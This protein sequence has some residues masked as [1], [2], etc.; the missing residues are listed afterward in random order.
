MEKVLGLPLK[1]IPQWVISCGLILLLLIALIPVYRLTLYAFPY[2]DD[3]N[4]GIN[5]KYAFEHGAGFSKVIKTAYEDTVFTYNTWQ[6]TYSSVFLMVLMP[7]A[8]GYQYYFIGLCAIITMFV[9]GTCYLTYTVCSKVFKASK[10]SSFNLAS[11]VTLMNVELFYEAQQGFYWY[12]SSIHYTFMHSL[13]F[14]LLAEIIRIVYSDKKAGTAFRVAVSS[15]LAFIVAGANFVT[16]LQGFLMIL[17][18]FLAGV[19]VIK[20]KR[21]IWALCPLLIFF[22][23]MILN[24]AAPGNASRQA[25]YADVAKGPVE[26]V[27]YSFLAG[28]KHLNEFT[29]FPFWAFF[30][31]LIPLAYMVA[32]SSSFNFKMPL[33]VT[34]LSFCFYSTG[35]TPSLYGMGY[36]GLARTFCAVKLVFLVLVAI[37]LIYWLGWIGK[38][39]DKDSEDG[40][41]GVLSFFENRAIVFVLSAALVVLSFAVSKNQ[42]GKFLTY[43]AYYYVHTGEALN[44]YNEH[45]VMDT[46]IKE[47]GDEVVLDP[48]VWRPWF[49]CKKDE[50]ETYP[51]AEQNQALARWYGK[52]EIY[53]SE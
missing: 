21:A 14:V 39:L 11:F 29:G 23:G 3:F 19:F 18:I 49:L 48:F 35:Y 7:A 45:M 32:K 33:L 15:I 31:G 30:V 5:V 8:F 10:L 22:A 42:A 37:N 52:R 36:D 6:G 9:L 12:N 47:A 25:I 16:G 41:E 13:M 50:L 34:A 40:K 26:S 51:M 17:F 4:Y 43:G 20:N 46:L 24:V 2:Y 38:K 27:L 28:F 53:I 1:K 44:Y